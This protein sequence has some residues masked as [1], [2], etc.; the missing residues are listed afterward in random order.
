MAVV[1]DRAEVCQF[2]TARRAELTPDQ[3]GVPLYGLSTDH[4]TRLEKG[5]LRGASDGALQ[6]IA[7]HCCPART[8]VDALRQEAPCDHHA[9]DLVGALVDLG[10]LGPQRLTPRLTCPFLARRHTGVTP[11]VP[12]RAPR[13]PRFQGD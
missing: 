11:A 2:L 12:Q 8:P 5:N 1:D 9:L 13:C 7:P 10:G 6:A 3:A 4:D